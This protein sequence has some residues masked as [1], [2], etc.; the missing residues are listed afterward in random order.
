MALTFLMAYFRAKLKS[1]DN[2]KTVFFIIKPTRCTNFTSLFWYETLHV[3]DSSS[4]HHQ[5]FIHCTFGSGIVIQ[6]CRELPSR[7]W[8]CSEALYTWCIFT[9]RTRLVL[10]WSYTLYGLVC[11]YFVSQWMLQ[12]VMQWDLNYFSMWLCFFCSWS[13]VQFKCPLWHS[14]L[15]FRWKG[16]KIKGTALFILPIKF[17]N[18]SSEVKFEYLT[19]YWAALKLA[20]LSSIIL[21]VKALSVSLNTEKYQLAYTTTHW[22]WGISFSVYAWSLFL[23]V[24]FRCVF[25]VLFVCMNTV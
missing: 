1:I 16:F 19:L 8:S 23:S 15:P 3:S 22:L 5:E 7:T 17:N 11:W 21:G 20:V 24:S 13:T 6:V 10:G 25:I 14:I 18:L 2:K 12:C 9:F 4:V